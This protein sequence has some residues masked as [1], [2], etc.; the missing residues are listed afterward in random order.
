[1]FR[2]IVAGIAVF[3]LLGFWLVVWPYLKQVPCPY[4][5]EKGFVMKG[6]IEI[7]CP[8]CGSAG[9]VPPY[10]RDIILAEMEKERKA[11]EA[12]RKQEAEEAAK[13]SS[14]YDSQPSYSEPQPVYSG[15]D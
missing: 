9:K 5:K 11:E 3:L 13:A 6:I 4:C 2:Y 12:K 14:S 8:Y 7:P 15:G 1:M 10:K